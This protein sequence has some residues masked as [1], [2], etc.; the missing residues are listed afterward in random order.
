M[1]RDDP[2]TT[3]APVAVF[4][5]PWPA[6]GV[7]LGA[8]AIALLAFQVFGQ[9]LLPFVLLAL[10]GAGV[11]VTIRPRS[12][13]VLGLAGLAAFGV[14]LGIDPAWDSA[15]LPV[16]VAVATAE[17]AALMMLLPRVVRRVVF[18]LFILFHFGGI[19]SAVNS[20]TPSPWL[21]WWSWLYIYRPYLEFM[22]LNNAYHF[23]SPEPG[24]G[25]LVRF[26][27]K[28]E[29]GTARW[30]Q[31]P[32]RE[33]NPS[34]LEYQRRLSL[35]QA[36][37]SLLTVPITPEMWKKRAE[38][39]RTTGVPPHPNVDPTMQYRV[40]NVY[41]KEILRS[42]ARHVAHD[43]VHPSDP[44]VKC[45]SVKIYRLVHRIL[46][47]AEMAQGIEPDEDWLYLAYY[48]GEYDPDGNLKDS[49]NPLLWWVI[50]IY[51]AGTDKDS[52][53]DYV[54]LHAESE[55]SVKAEQNPTGVQ[56]FPVIPGAPDTKKQ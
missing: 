16:V 19:L 11:A 34:A 8:A 17:V 10:L 21:A 52:V 45:T 3:G 49:D 18:S 30:F 54:Q 23:Y 12:P 35:T 55:G 6:I 39:T 5:N 50:P 14:C 46:P 48:Q 24:P 40:P 37:N 38:A 43:V 26:Y 25:D 2:G 44:G 28:Y 36:V 27:V 41:S 33:D 56:G 53:V 29:D 32:R 42:F 13:L 20:V 15:R 4:K 31:I 22:Y 7:G 9:A 47:P 51:K 1:D